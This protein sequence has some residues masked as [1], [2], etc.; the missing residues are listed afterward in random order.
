MSAWEGEM[1]EFKFRWWDKEIKKMRDMQS[2]EIDQC[3]CWIM[4]DEIAHTMQWTGLKDKNG[5]DIYEDD[6]LKLD[7]GADIVNLCVLWHSPTA[8]WAV[9][10]PWR[11]EPLNLCAYVDMPFCTVEIIGNIQENPELLK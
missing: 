6:I 11:K 10:T 4:D 2:A 5:K 1:R 9:S 3:W 8:G 7:G